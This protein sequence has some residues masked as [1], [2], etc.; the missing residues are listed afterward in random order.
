LAACYYRTP[1]PGSKE[2]FND[3]RRFNNAK[4]GLAALF[5]AA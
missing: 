2:K 3:S 5:G 4:G 1:P